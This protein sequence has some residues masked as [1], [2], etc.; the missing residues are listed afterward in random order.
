MQSHPRANEAGGLSGKPLTTRSTEVIAAFS[1][2]F[3][4]KLPII[5]AGGISSVQDAQ[6]KLRA[7]ASLVQIYSSFIYQGPAL[8]KELV[9]QR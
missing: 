6:E 4:G 2:A 8:V 1:S 3:D 9:Q 7:G 5:G